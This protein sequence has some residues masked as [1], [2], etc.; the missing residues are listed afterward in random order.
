M[1]QDS[2]MI[3]NE[4]EIETQ[5]DESGLCLHCWSIQNNLHRCEG[6]CEFD[7]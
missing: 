1:K 2:C 6:D 7:W 3:C 4:C 5:F